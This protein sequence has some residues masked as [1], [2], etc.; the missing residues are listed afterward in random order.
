[1]GHASTRSV[2]RQIEVLFEGGSAAGLSDRQL[3]ERFTA[4]RDSSAEAAFAALVARH[5]PMVMR[6]CRDLVRDVHHGEDAFQAVFLVLACKAKSIRDPGLLGNWLFG[7]AV[8][9]ALRSRSR[10]TRQRNKEGGGVMR[11]SGT[12][13]NGAV[14]PVI[15]ANREST[16]GS[17]EIATMH[18]EISRLPKAFRL[19]VVLCYF[20]GLTLDE[21]ARSLCWPTGTVRSRLARGRDKLRRA[22]SRRGFALSATAVIV[23]LTSRSASAQFSSAVCETT[24]RA[25]VEFAAGQAGGQLVSASVAALAREI[26]SS[27]LTR[28]VMLLVVAMAF[29]GAAGAAY[30]I[31]SATLQQEPKSATAEPKQQLA[32]KPE[33][34]QQPPAPGRMF[35]VGR[36]LDPESKPV[37]GATVMAYARVPLPG[38]AYDMARS[39]RFRSD[40]PKAMD[41]ASFAW[42]RHAPRHPEMMVLAQSHLRRDSVPAGLRSMSTPSNPQRI[43]WFGVNS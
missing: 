38:H 18:K 20:E 36:V 22:L 15:D 21:A 16:L 31:G 9:T 7:V 25:A 29:L 24:A 37:A 32:A 41:R 13:S 43:F 5:G 26:L 12:D 28:R 27:M 3:L 35:I 6:V 4:N 1:M 2:V 11:H 14:E 30:A 17:D 34:T 40:M 19:P 33:N 23:G 42:M 8:R 10:L 39:T